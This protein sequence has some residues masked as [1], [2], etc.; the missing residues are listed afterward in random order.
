MNPETIS[1]CRDCRVASCA[2]DTL[3]EDE[4]RTIEND[5][6]QTSFKKGEIIR[7]QGAPL[8]SVIYLRE[9]YVK[10]YMSYESVADQVIQLIK[11]RSYIGLQGLYTNAT[12]VFSYQATTDARVCFIEKSVFSDIICNNGNFAREILISLSQESISNHKR[13]LSLNQTQNFG[14]V[15]GLIIYLSEEIYETSEFDLPLNRAEM[16]QMI[17]STRESVTRA[18][19]WFHNQGIINMEKNRIRIEQM[20]RLSEIAKRG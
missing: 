17:A 13:F 4:L 18:L 8:D 1:S 20:E 19:K 5:R 14:K 11:P 12:S 15:A 16:G 10:E 6:Y 7:K 9:G 2:I 3:S